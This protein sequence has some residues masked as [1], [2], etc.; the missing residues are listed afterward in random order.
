MFN[1]EQYYKLASRITR[2]T[3]FDSLF[4][5]YKEDTECYSQRFIFND[6]DNYYIMGSKDN[7]EVIVQ[8]NKEMQSNL[9][10]QIEMLITNR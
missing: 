8:L 7:A 9:L 5:Q 6:N 3:S 2:K 10:E 4:D 1:L